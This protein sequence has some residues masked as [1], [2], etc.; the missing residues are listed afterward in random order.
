M[1]FILMLS[2][3]TIEEGIVDSGMTEE[4]NSTERASILGETLL[5]QNMQ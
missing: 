3:V 4:S 2:L 5:Y 1:I